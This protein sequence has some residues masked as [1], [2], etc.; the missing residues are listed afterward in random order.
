[1]SAVHPV[2]DGLPPA[3][4]ATVYRWFPSWRLLTASLLCLCFASVH[5]MNSNMGM[6]VVCMVNS[7]EYMDDSALDPDAAP[8]LNWTSEQEGYIFSAFNGG[9][10][11]MLLTGFIAD[12]FNAKY[13][14]VA[15]VSL[16]VVA[17]LLIAQFSAV[18]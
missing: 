18:R 11:L 8:R 5:M 14:I 9:L 3:P 13:M 1:M 4:R 16:A 12:K 2:S 15:S 10:L 17:N 6:A 7:T